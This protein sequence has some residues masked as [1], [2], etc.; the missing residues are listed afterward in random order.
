MD[1]RERTELNKQ[2]KLVDCVSHLNSVLEAFER[3]ED[4]KERVLP[5][6]DGFDL[7]HTDTYLGL[8]ENLKRELFYIKFFSE[9]AA[10]QLVKYRRLCNPDQDIYSIKEKK[11][12]EKYG[13]KPL[14]DWKKRSE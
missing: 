14:G 12:Q 6:I 7:T 4:Y 5:I 13:I 9:H 10:S 3:L 8:T 11:N 1:E 2:K